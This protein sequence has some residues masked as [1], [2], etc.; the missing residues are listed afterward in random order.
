MSSQKSISCGKAYKD[1][2]CRCDFLSIIASI[3]NPEQLPDSDPAIPSDIEPFIAEITGKAKVNSMLSYFEW[4]DRSDILQ[5]QTDPR[6]RATP[7][8]LQ[9]T[10]DYYLLSYCKM[11][12]L[13]SKL[14]LIDTGTDSFYAV[15]EIIESAWQDELEKPI[16]RRKRI[17]SVLIPNR[18]YHYSR[19]SPKAKEDL[20]CKYLFFPKNA[21]A[22]LFS[23]GTNTLF[24]DPIS[25]D[26]RPSL[27]AL[28]R[29]QHFAVDDYFFY[30]YFTGACLSLEITAALM[31]C[32]ES[33][34]RLILS[35]LQS[36]SERLVRSP[37]LLTRSTIARQYIFQSKEAIGLGEKHFKQGDS[38][39]LQKELDN[40]AKE[41]CIDA[42][43][44]RVDQM[45]QFLYDPYRHSCYYSNG[46]PIQISC[47][48]P[49]CSCHLDAP[50]DVQIRMDFFGE[51]LASIQ[52]PI[53]I[54]GYAGFPKCG[55]LAFCNTSH[56]NVLEILSDAIIPIS[57]SGEASILRK[58]S[59]ACVLFN[60][61]QKMVIGAIEKADLKLV[62]ALQ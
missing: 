22:Q 24:I 42:A 18:T 13:K 37:M 10:F 59:K 33:V 49:V 51:M 55:P 6:L 30:E 41:R 52:G 21:T 3:A 60:E 1:C 5:Y 25:L 56:K 40:A 48:S 4:T 27:I 34:R 28:P 12:Y 29:K 54:C 16:K 61:V 20:L 9:R 31:E 26:R 50:G 44:R 53:D 58:R 43:F 32:P 46:I 19:F 11:Q 45:S 8:M 15:H 17:P 36:R 23:L 14:D 39:S 57:K 38:A 35:K 62:T 47:S 2:T 7:Y